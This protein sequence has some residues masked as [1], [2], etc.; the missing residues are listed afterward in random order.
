LPLALLQLTFPAAPSMIVTRF[1]IDLPALQFTLE[2]VG[3][4]W[5]VG[6]QTSQLKAVVLVTVAL[7]TTAP[8]PVRGTPPLPVT[9]ISRVVSGP[10]RLTPPVPFRVSTIRL[11]TRGTTPPTV[12][13]PCG[14]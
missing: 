9:W 13:E 8:A 10:S 14:S 12:V 2:A 1:A 7:N 6:Q 3:C 11:G 5:P 4:A